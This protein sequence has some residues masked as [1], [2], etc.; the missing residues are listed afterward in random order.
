M[1]L[2]IIKEARWSLNAVPLKVISTFQPLNCVFK[3]ELDDLDEEALLEED[4]ALELL[5]L[6]EDALEEALEFDDL[7]SFELL[8]EELKDSEIEL[9]KLLLNENT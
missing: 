6:L 3:D 1:P 9:D 4:D 7:E 2:A 8:L 5:D